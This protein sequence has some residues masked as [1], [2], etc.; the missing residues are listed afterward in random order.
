M[1][2]YG[3]QESRKRKLLGMLGALCVVLG[4]LL[5]SGVLYRDSLLPV[6]PEEEAPQRQSG[7]AAGE[8]SPQAEK[9]E[10]S[11]LPASEPA[12]SE[13]EG[14]EPD[15]F[16]QYREEAARVMEDMTLR[17]KV[18]Q[19][20]VFLCPKTDG[21]ALIE[22][23][24]PGGLCLNAANFENKTKE[25]VREMTAGYQNVS[26]L[27]L[28]TCCDEEGGTVT[29]ISRFPALRG[30]P[31]QSPRQVY[32]SGGMEAVCSDTAEKAQ[33]LK[34]LGINANLAPV[35]DLSGSPEDFIYDRSFGED[36][37][38]VSEFIRVSAEIYAE[39]GVACVLKHFPG[40]GDNAD[41]HTGLAWDERAYAEF[42]TRDFLPFQAGFEAGA[43]IVLVNHN[44]VECMDPER[45]A[46]LS[47]EV[48]RI[49]RE[50]L[51]FG[52][53]IMTDDLEMGAIPRYTGGENPAL[54]AFL[55]GNDLLLCSE[56][57]ES[58]SVLLEA[59]E[60]GEVSEERL[61][62]SVLRVLEWKCSMGLF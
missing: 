54:Q 43:P 10:S 29:R 21:E 22:T 42:Q 41:T 51:G 58:F 45:P 53:L 17:E 8:N 19:V 36:P 23:Y 31:F 24:A 13:P 46:T 16:S 15:I 9:T 48:H 6:E 4:G 30:E 61:E 26:K 44:I 60:S 47:P 7:K 55:A 11:A 40:Y 2:E 56:P 49:L 12:V 57:E 25:E 18:G 62:A 5:V 38:S 3:K 1:G 35:A 28:L 20:F 50:E 52:G 39:N 27:P 37:E 59:V 32:T 33:L 14:M 34:S